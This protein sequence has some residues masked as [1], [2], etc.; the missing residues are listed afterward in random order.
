VH[1]AR[2]GA[3][4]FGLTEA[5][6]EAAFAAATTANFDRLFTRAAAWRKAA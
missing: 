4:L 2:V 6:F 5:A 1:T 3:E